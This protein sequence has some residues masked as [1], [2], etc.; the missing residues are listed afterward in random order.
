MLF[1]TERSAHPAVEESGGLREAFGHR[2]LLLHH[3]GLV[4]LVPCPGP[5][6][7]DQT[8]VVW[9]GFGMHDD[10]VDGIRELPPAVRLASRAPSDPDPSAVFHGA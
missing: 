3:D 8:P 4:D 9:R 2:L 1:S 10:S 7:E 6:H 5:F